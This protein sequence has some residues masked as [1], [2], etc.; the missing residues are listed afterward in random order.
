MERAWCRRTCRVAARRQ[1]RWM[2]TASR[3]GGTWTCT[4]E[5]AGVALRGKPV[6]GA[7]LV[8]LARRREGREKLVV[9]QGRGSPYVSFPS[10]AVDMLDKVVAVAVSCSG[11]WAATGSSQNW[12]CVWD[13][14]APHVDPQENQQGIEAAAFVI[15]WHD[16]NDNLFLSAGASVRVWDMRDAGSA[17]ASVRVWD[18]RDGGRT[19]AMLRGKVESRVESLAMASVRGGMDGGGSE[20]ALVGHE[21][22]VV[23]LWD[24]ISGEA[25]ACICSD[26]LPSPALAVGFLPGSGMLVTCGLDAVCVL[27]GNGEQLAVSGGGPLLFSSS[28]DS[29]GPV[30]AVACRAGVILTGHEYGG[31]AAWVVEEA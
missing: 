7:V 9:V 17:G 2:G 18:V 4:R 1:R 8:S 30:T 3:G 29:C 19:V 5:G 12:L 22:G 24:A 26:K 20:H 28:D 23:Q 13:L 27:H 6:V 21:N 11:R 16:T 15:A 10:R 31:V 14:H 25:L